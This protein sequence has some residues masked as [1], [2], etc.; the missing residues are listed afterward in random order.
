SPSSITTKKFGT[1]MHTLGLNPT[2][3]ELQ[4]VISEVG[5]IDFHKFL[6]LIA[7]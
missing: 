6:S 5:N 4:D 7:C 3:A 1:M 2:K